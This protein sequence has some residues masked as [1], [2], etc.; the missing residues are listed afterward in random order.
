MNRR[1]GSAQ[2]FKQ[3][4]N[5]CHWK[6]SID[7]WAEEI[8]AKWT[9]STWHSIESGRFHIDNCQRSMN[10]RHKFLEPVAELLKYWNGPPIWLIIKWIHCDFR[11]LKIVEKCERQWKMKLRTQT[12]RRQRR[13]RR[14]RRRFRGP[15]C[16]CFSFGFKFSAP[17]TMARAGGLFPPFWCFMFYY[18][19]S[20]LVSFCCRQKSLVFHLAS[21][22]SPLVFNS[23]R[24]IVAVW[25]PFLTRFRSIFICCSDFGRFIQLVLTQFQIISFRYWNCC[26][27]LTRFHSI[28]IDLFNLI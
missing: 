22:I 25:A 5:F 7:N 1:I 10:R 4:W 26:S 2:R 15:I 21:C 12:T 28:F 13:Q 17:T 19:D 18:Y 14:Q 11:Q 24:L 3:R 16:F 6:L 8:E 27:I 23:F 20:C 9:D